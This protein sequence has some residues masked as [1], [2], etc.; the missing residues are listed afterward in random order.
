MSVHRS[1]FVLFILCGSLWLNHG[2]AADARPKPSLRPNIRWYLPEIIDGSKPKVKRVVVSGTSYPGTSIAVRDNRITLIRKKALTVPLSKVTS[3]KFPLQVRQDGYFEMEFVLPHSDVQI[4][5]EITRLGTTVNY[6][7]VFKVQKNSVTM[8]SKRQ[9]ERSPY[10]SRPYK[11]WF[12][13]GYTYL[14]YKQTIQVLQGGASDPSFES[15]RGP[16]LFFRGTA[17]VHKRWS[18]GAEY[19]SSPGLVRD[20]AGISISGGAYNWTTL[21][22]EGYYHSDLKFNAASYPVET[23]LRAGLQHHTVPFLS[24]Q[25]SSPIVELKYNTVT[26]ATFGFDL[27]IASRN[28]IYY[29]IYMRYQLPLTTGPLFDLSTKFAFDGSLGAMYRLTSNWL[30]GLFWYGQWHEYNFTRSAD[31]KTGSQSLFYSNL[32][33]RVG[34]QF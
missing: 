17:R 18:V 30:L 4:P 12:G 25:A 3:T 10:L 22:A 26:M 2:M 1:V 15:L 20:G 14:R 29:E 16:S 31:K 7:L 28:R 11:I 8:A 9:L 5:F 32:D 27:S 33:L 19:K 13:P 23:G 21:A 6:T 24:S 34:Y